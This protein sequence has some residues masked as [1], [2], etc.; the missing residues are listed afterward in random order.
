MLKKLK[1]TH[2]LSSTNFQFKRHQFKSFLKDNFFKPANST[3]VG[4]YGIPGLFQPSDISKNAENSIKNILQTT[5]KII[6]TTIDSASNAKKVIFNLDNISNELCLLLDPYSL[7]SVSHSNVNWVNAANEALQGFG[8]ILHE[9]NTNSDLHLKMCEIVE[10]KII[11]DQLNEQEKKLVHLFKSDMEKQGGSH[12]SPENKQKILKL[13]SEI[14]QIMMEFTTSINEHDQ[15]LS[16]KL[17]TRLVTSRHS[18]ATLLGQPSFAHLSLQDQMIETPEKAVEFL[19]QIHKSVREK[20]PLELQILSHDSTGKQWLKNPKADSQ[21]IHYVLDKVANNLTNVVP[22]EEYF[23]LNNCLN[24]LN[25]ICQRLFGITLKPC[26]VDP[27][28]IWHQDVRKISF[29]HETEGNLGFLYLDLFSRSK[30]ISASATS[31]IALGKKISEMEYQNPVIALLISFPKRTS[32][33]LLNLSQVS[34]LFHEFGHAI[35]SILG[36]TDFQNTSGTRTAIDFIETPSQFF[37]HFA[38]DYR[39]VSTFAKHYVTGEVLPEELLNRYKV[40]QNIFSC[41]SLEREI[42]KSFIDL[43]I[44]GIPSQKSFQQIVSHYNERYSSIPYDGH[45]NPFSIHSTNYAAAYYSYTYSKVFSSHI[46]HK[47]FAKDPFSREAG[48]RFRMKC[49]HHGGIKSPKEILNEFLE[50]EPNPEYLLKDLI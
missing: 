45:E 6:D 43:E 2:K 29:E 37:E 33:K 1:F 25:T 39:V 23:S 46:W 20:I 31:T 24:G 11:F 7:C 22:I 17:F 14:D 35:H 48:E 19:H 44:Y 21:T 8:R 40:K 5:N 18:L 38:M 27:N 12:L 10:N 3:P 13:N 30:K 9:L 4:L 26:E 28:E 42:I 16:M 50:E 36:R 47:Y 32:E 15:D 34:T 41:L 49:L